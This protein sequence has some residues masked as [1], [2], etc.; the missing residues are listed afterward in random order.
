M[1]FIKEHDIK[2]HLELAGNPVV[3]IIGPFRLKNECLNYKRIHRV[4]N[5]ISKLFLNDH[6]LKNSEFTIQKSYI[7][8]GKTLPTP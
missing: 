1:S 6:L 5:K 3:K 2:L 8:I 4:T 7:N